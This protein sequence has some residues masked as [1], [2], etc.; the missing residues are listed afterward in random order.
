MSE[1][2][3]IT[4]TMVANAACILAFVVALTLFVL[5]QFHVV[6]DSSETLYV[7]IMAA[8]AACLGGVTV[9]DHRAKSGPTE[10]PR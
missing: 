5:A 1:P 8:L 2:K 10:P 4:G 7:I 6:D 3:K 9:A